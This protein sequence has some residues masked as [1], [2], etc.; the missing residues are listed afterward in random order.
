MHFTRH[1]LDEGGSAK[2]REM[3]KLADRIYGPRQ[4]SIVSADYKDATDRLSKEGSAYVASLMSLE[5][6]DSKEEWKPLFNAIKTLLSQHEVHYDRKFFDEKL[7]EYLEE[8][9]YVLPG[10]EAFNAFHR[11][12]RGEEAP[13]KSWTRTFV[14]GIQQDG[15]L[16]GSPVSFGVLCLVNLAVIRSILFGIGHPDAHKLVMV[17]GDDGVFI[18]P[19]THRHLYQ[20]WEWLTTSFGL[21]LSAGK[22]YVSDACDKLPFLTFNSKMYT[23][24]WDNDSIPNLNYVP[25]VHSALYKGWTKLEERIPDKANAESGIGVRCRELLNGFSEEDAGHLRGR[26][27]LHWAWAMSDPKIIHPSVSW[28]LPEAFGGLGIPFR[29]GDVV[30]EERLRDAR[31]L[32]S[33]YEFPA[34][35]SSLEMEPFQLFELT[36]STIFGK[37][38]LAKARSFVESQLFRE[39]KLRLSKEPFSGWSPISEE[40]RDLYLFGKVHSE[41]LRDDRPVYERMNFNALQKALTCMKQVGTSEFIKK[42]VAHFDW[43]QPRDFWNQPYVVPDTEIESK[44]HFGMFDSEVRIMGLSGVRYAQRLIGT[45][46]LVGYLADKLAEE[47]G[48]SFFIPNPDFYR[49]ASSAAQLMSGNVPR[50]YCLLTGQTLDKH[51]LGETFLSEVFKQSE[52]VE[53]LSSEVVPRRCTSLEMDA[54][55]YA[56]GGLSAPALA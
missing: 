43:M 25:Y 30:S 7:P 46:R 12:I 51:P 45:N 8:V 24:T 15:Q 4:Y 49:A 55:S 14:R 41:K 3:I 2:I 37:T 32:R 52:P 19:H 56:E 54:R 10:Y 40:I 35:C 18:I 13:K 26:F 16:M 29:E 34:L 21:A 44:F 38:A 9:S 47:E 36:R 6:G 39:V 22:N 27:L 31:F 1:A 28:F 42:H 50:V 48:R 17:N 23:I 11:D 5:F 53:V 33:L 20:T